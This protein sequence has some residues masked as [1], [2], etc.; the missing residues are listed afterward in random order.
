MLIKSK[1][2]S[3]FLQ[4]QGPAVVGKP[5]YNFSVAGAAGK[6]QANIDFQTGSA[7]SFTLDNQITGFKI[8]PSSVPQ[9]T[10]LICTVNINQG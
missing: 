9:G 10:T 5:A 4:A 7:A 3:C 1:F 2:Y 8:E 6:C